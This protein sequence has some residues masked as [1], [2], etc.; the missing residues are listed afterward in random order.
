MSH[1]KNR[2]ILT[3]EICHAAGKDVANRR[4]RSEGRT[5]WNVDDY[6]AACK[7]INRLFDIM[8]EQQKLQQVDHAR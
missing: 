2:M 8:D 7:E 1:R 3:P 5:T 4:M 6:N